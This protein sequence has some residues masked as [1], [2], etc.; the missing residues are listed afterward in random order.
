MKNIILLVLIAA[1]G[2]QATDV[3][4]L[5]SQDEAKK[6]SASK[7]KPLLVFHYIDNDE[8]CAN[9]L[10][11][12]D[13]DTDTVNNL[14]SF[15]CVKVNET[16][17]RQGFKEYPVVQF[18][19]PAGNEFLLK[20]FINSTNLGK[21]NNILSDILYQISQGAGKKFDTPV[22]QA[23]STVPLGKAVKIR[24]SVADR[25]FSVI[26]VYGPGSVLIKKLFFGVTKPGD[27]SVE[28][29]QKGADGKA[30]TTGEYF[31]VFDTPSFKDIV[32]IRII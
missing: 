23:P 10:K 3:N 20:R 4:W 6:E 19:S 32:E 25:G 11:A 24:Y 28:W 2:I 14:K 15:A 27:Y 30:V 13:N 22:K 29:D 12:I 8:K 9:L 1:G 17:N 31:I 16:D 5:K 7:S 26:K 21:F 18:F